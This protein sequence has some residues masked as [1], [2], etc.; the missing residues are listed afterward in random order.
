MLRTIFPVN[1]DYENVVDEDEQEEEE[2]KQRLDW[3]WPQAHKCNTVTTFY[4][5]SF[6]QYTCTHANV[7]AHTHKTHIRYTLAVHAH[8][9]FLSWKY[10]KLH[11]ELD[12]AMGIFH[13][14]ATCLCWYIRATHHP[15]YYRYMKMD[16][17]PLHL[18]I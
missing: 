4:H 2:E 13:C 12:L 8:T 10:K 14:N 11:T 5:A 9:I 18:Q 16:E 6:Y 3:P 7:A 17:T 15:D 1:E